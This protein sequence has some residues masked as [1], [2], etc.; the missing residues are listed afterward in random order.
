LASYQVKHIQNYKLNKDLVDL[1]LILEYLK[2]ETYLR[3]LGLA[4]L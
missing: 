2:K 4:Q 3:R 1:G